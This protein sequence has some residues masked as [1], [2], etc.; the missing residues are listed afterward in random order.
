MAQVKDLPQHSIFFYGT[1][2]HSSILSRVLSRPVSSLI[3]RP[4]TL[5]NHARHQVKHADYPAVITASE[6]FYLTS[7]SDCSV[8]GTLVQGL[9]ESDIRF[10]DAFEGEEYERIIVTVSTGEEETE[11]YVYKWV[12]GLGQ[13]SERLWLYE[14]FLR[15]KASRWVGKEG[16]EEYKEAD[17]LRGA[18]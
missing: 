16:E 5:A 4:A 11:A 2:M 6:S 12:A 7:R 8:D 1:L 9:T 14:D 13:L 18:I 15:E 10:L 17:A 3:I